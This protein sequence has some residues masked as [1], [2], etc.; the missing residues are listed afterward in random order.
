MAEEIKRILVHLHRL[1][2]MNVPDSA[3]SK[4]ISNPKKVPSY[5]YREAVLGPFARFHSKLLY[6]KYQSQSKLLDQ[7][8]SGSNFCLI[9]LD[10]CRYDFLN[11]V[12]DDYFEGS[13]DP[14]WANALDTFE[15]QRKLWTET[16]EYPYITAAAPVTSQSFT[17]EEEEDADGMAMAGS[18][19]RD[20]YQGYLP[21]EHF[22]NLVEVWRESW[23][24]QLGVCPP[25]PVTNRA[26]D[27]SST[28]DKMVIH[29]FQPHGPFIGEVRRTGSLEDYK[30]DVAGGAVEK[31]IWSAAR[32][33]DISLRE[34]RDMYMSN[35]DR[36]LGAV[37]ELIME[38]DYEKYLVMG[39]HGEALGEYGQFYHSIEH[40]KVR[41]V[42]W[43]S[44]TGVKGSV[45]DMWE[46]NDAGQS[47]DQSTTARLRELGYIE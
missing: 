20:R 33:G 28:S 2:S 21:K 41:E 42:P 7:L 22:L 4:A 8:R 44:I 10:A 15:Y 25:E 34:L 38:T 11:K 13:C 9:V 32:S 18:E 47:L 5:L 26:I 29:Y 40:P 12:F 39:D 37:G 43:A 46:Y 1:Q 36:V 24:E 23:D 14:I 30:T 6:N 3:V 45:P 35:L 31:G 16:Y 27:L 17:F 19:L